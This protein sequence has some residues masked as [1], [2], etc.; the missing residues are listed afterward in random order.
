MF[1][2]LSRFLG[3]LRRL[4]SPFLVHQNTRI[5]SSINHLAH[6][7]FCITSLKSIYGIPILIDIHMGSL[8]AIHNIP[9]II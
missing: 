5:N 1:Y 7:P 8:K 2:H 9:K 3:E 4:D 6:L